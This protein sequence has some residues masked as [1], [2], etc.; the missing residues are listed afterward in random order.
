MPGHAEGI[1]RGGIA[2]GMAVITRAGGFGTATSLSE[3][4]RR[5]LST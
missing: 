5:T 1:I 2:D 4:L 3:L